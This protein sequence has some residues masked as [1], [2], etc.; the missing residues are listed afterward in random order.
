MPARPR[1]P[2]RRHPDLLGQPPYRPLADLIPRVIVRVHGQQ[3]RVRINPW[4]H[5]PCGPGGRHPHLLH[6]MSGQG[7]VLTPVQGHGSD[8]RGIHLRGP[9]LGQPSKLG[10]PGRRLQQPGL[11][12]RQ[13]WPS[14]PG[15][16]LPAA[17]ARGPG[18]PL[19][20]GEI[21]AKFTNLKRLGPSLFTNQLADLCQHP[22]VAAGDGG[23]VL[24]PDQ[25][26]LVEHLTVQPFDG[27]H[28]PLNHLALRLV[29]DLDVEVVHEDTRQGV[30]HVIVDPPDCR[31]EQSRQLEDGGGAPRRDASGREERLTNQP[32]HRNYPC[33]LIGLETH[34]KFLQ[35]E[36]LPSRSPR[37]FKPA[38]LVEGL[39][40]VRRSLNYHLLTGPN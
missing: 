34:K 3:R 8:S 13:S 37:E 21:D 2:G 19:A 16:A 22:V 36:A 33:P 27:R 12:D 18:P 35:G 11:L 6:L 23:L 1:L 7:R 15:Y 14:Y 28:R 38:D 31:H 32:I 5:Q 29:S 40:E 39:L 25:P 9:P 17:G 26:E 20:E 30:R 24:R 10:S 4:G